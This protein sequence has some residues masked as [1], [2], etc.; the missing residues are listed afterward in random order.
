MIIIQKYT[1]PGNWEFSV[2]SRMF[3]YSCNY[4]KIK[5]YLEIGMSHSLSVAFSQ[6]FSLISFPLGRD[7]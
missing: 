3:L 7:L 4:V 5:K 1:K 6:T 2:S